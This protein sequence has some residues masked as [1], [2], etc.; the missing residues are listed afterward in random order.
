[1]LNGSDMRMTGRQK[2]LRDE[3]IAAMGNGSL[4]FIG[5]FGDPGP[6]RRITRVARIS[7]GGY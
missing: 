6:F 2:R 5:R 3:A 7:A 4:Q 1:V